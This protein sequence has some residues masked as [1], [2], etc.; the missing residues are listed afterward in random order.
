MFICTVRNV[1][2]VLKKCFFTANHLAEKEN[3][4]LYIRNVCHTVFLSLQ[5]NFSLPSSPLSFRAK[6]LLL[7]L[8]WWSDPSAP[9]LSASILGWHSDYLGSIPAL[10]TLLSGWFDDKEI[11]LSWQGNYFFPVVVLIVTSLSWERNCTRLLGQCTVRLKT[12][13]KTLHYE[14]CPTVF[15][16]NVRDFSNSI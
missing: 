2:Q 5:R 10:C 1:Y 6:S 14:I 9:G 4:V 13:E 15:S 3:F 11:F 7:S 8:F 12:V 16:P